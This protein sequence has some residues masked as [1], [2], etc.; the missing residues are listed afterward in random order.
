MTRKLIF[1]VDL[2]RDVN[3][4]V[5]GH[6]EARSI[7]RGFGDDPRFSSSEIGLRL[8]TDLLDDINIKATFFVEGRTAESIDCSYIYGHTIG[9]H[10]YDHEDLLGKYTGIKLDAAR[11]TKILEKGTIAVTDRI[12]HPKCFRAPYMAINEIVFSCM[13]NIGIHIDSSLY[14]KISDTYTHESRP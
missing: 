6:I 8:I 5:K 11:I 10:G 13:R 14:S 3:V 1:T 4:P 2:D 9:L 7:D 12:S